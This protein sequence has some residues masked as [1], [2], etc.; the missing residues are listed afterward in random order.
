MLGDFL[1]PRIL[2]LVCRRFIRVPG[3]VFCS[4]V[5]MYAILRFALSYFRFDEQTV[6]GIPVP[7]L[8]SGILL[9]IAII[10]AGIL[11][12]HPG[13]SP[14]STRPRRLGRSCVRRMTTD[15]PPESPQ[16]RPESWPRR[17]KSPSTA[18]P[19]A[20]S[21]MKRRPCSR[22]IAPS[23]APAT[24][25]NVAISTR[26]PPS[27]R[28]TSS[29]SRSYR[30]RAGGSRAG[31]DHGT[32]ARSTAART[33]LTSRAAQARQVPSRCP[34]RDVPCRRTHPISRLG[35][36]CVATAITSVRFSRLIL[37]ANAMPP[38]E[39][40]SARIACCE[41]SSKFVSS[42]APV[43]RAAP[44]TIERRP[45]PGIESRRSVSPST[46]ANATPPGQPTDARRHRQQHVLAQERFASNRESATGRTT[47]AR[48]NSS[49]RTRS[50][51]SSVPRHLDADVAARMAGG[52]ARPARGEA[53]CRSPSRSRTSRAN[54]CVPNRGRLSPRASRRGRRT[55][56]GA[57]GEREGRR[58]RHHSAAYR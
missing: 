39:A 23:A 21:A 28:A 15:D 58:R 17:W 10:A 46:S 3:W 26:M 54:R 51:A 45:S 49:S 47:S 48:S 7:Q 37:G 1:Y 35:P 19:A 4:Y 57:V 12:R 6:S 33:P 24:V 32:R 31:A 5:A 38:P 52:G 44:S 13:R 2:L 20:A 43:A 11:Y 27:R 41:R 9:G 29:R 36:G 50:I 18:K 55:P 16:P 53:G 22:R 8:T 40:T 56:V 14:R 30:C 42:V 25:N 34:V